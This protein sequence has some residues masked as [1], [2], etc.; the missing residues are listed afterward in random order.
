MAIPTA[1][2]LT[3][4]AVEAKFSGDREAAKALKIREKNA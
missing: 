1:W 3:F 4:E 2:V